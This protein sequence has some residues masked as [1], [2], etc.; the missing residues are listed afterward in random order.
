MENNDYFNSQKDDGYSMAS[1]FGSL[2]RWVWLEH[3]LQ[4]SEDSAEWQVRKEW[5]V[6]LKAHRYGAPGECLT[7][8][9]LRRGPSRDFFRKVLKVSL[10]RSSS[11]HR[12]KRI[13][14]HRCRFLELR[15]PV[16]D[17]PSAKSRRP[18]K[19]SSLSEHSSRH[20][21]EISKS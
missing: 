2:S 16:S 11:I 14:W 10:D 17:E 12:W 15:S 21:R 4:E 1:L 8:G 7:N 3:C 20:I 18:R 5:K 9:R 19:D 13:L 6:S